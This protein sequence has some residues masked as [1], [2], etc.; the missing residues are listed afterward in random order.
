M[1]FLSWF[2]VSKQQKFPLSEFQQESVPFYYDVE[3]LNFIERD[4]LYKF[5]IY[6][7]FNN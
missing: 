4:Y 2:F 6:K 1:V 3:I 5:L 7:Y